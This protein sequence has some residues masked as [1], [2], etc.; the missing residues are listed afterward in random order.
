MSYGRPGRY[1]A[2][3]RRKARREGVPGGGECHYCGPTTTKLERAFIDAARKMLPPETF[4][5][6]EKMARQGLGNQD[7]EGGS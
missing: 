7:H 3:F 2:H 5:A 1:A 6:I 4:A